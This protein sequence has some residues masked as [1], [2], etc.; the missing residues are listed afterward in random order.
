LT[1]EASI[2][3]PAAAPAF[4]HAL[5]NPVYRPKTAGSLESVP[6]TQ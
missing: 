3:Q 1:L 6:S 4:C 5:K 2:F